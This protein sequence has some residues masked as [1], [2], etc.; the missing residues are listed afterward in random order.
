M[1]TSLA[2]LWCKVKHTNLLNTGMALLSLA[3]SVKQGIYQM[4]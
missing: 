1:D 4:K 3:F 2:T